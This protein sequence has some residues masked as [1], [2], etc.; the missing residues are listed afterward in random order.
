VALGIEIPDTVYAELLPLM[1]GLNYLY[2]YDADLK[3]DAMT[4]I[5][6]TTEISGW[7]RIN[8]IHG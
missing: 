2:R 6:F 7:K 1:A 4:D 8:N 5:E 3:R